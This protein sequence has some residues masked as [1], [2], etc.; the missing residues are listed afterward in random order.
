MRQWID[1]LIRPRRMEPTRFK[2]PKCWRMVPLVERTT[3]FCEAGPAR[4]R[5]NHIYTKRSSPNSIL[6]SGRLNTVANLFL[7]HE[8]P[9]G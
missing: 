4:H 7:Q 2:G 8:R 1:A 6:V 3:N 5:Q 9:W